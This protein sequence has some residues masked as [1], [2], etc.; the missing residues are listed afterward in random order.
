MAQDEKPWIDA[1]LWRWCAHV[2]Q[3]AVADGIIFFVCVGII[4]LC[5]KWL[6]YTHLDKIQVFSWLSINDIVTAFH[7]ANLVV[8]LSFLLYHVAKAHRAH[9]P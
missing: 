6:K 2:V 5:H 7:V 9:S 8:N 1:G 4:S 3:L